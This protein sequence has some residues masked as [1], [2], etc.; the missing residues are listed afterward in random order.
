MEEAGRSSFV[1]G[2]DF[3]QVAARHVALNW[4]ATGNLH[5]DKSV[6]WRARVYVLRMVEVL[7]TVMAR[8][9]VR[10]RVLIV[11]Q[12][13]LGL[14]CCISSHAKLL[15]MLDYK[16]RRCTAVAS[17]STAVPCLGTRVCRRCS[18]VAAATEHAS[19]T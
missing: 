18:T 8:G 3:S 9:R 15:E 19:I 11:E 6:E 1:Q 7:G 2:L 17:A 14:A 12:T 5:V 10:Y 13:S 16:R 4:I